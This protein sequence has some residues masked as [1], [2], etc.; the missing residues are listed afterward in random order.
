MEYKI[1]IEL[2]MYEFPWK[3]LESWEKFRTLP[4]TI[5]NEI[6]DGLSPLKSSGEVEKHYKTF[7]LFFLQLSLLLQLRPT[8]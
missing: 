6:T 4:L 3:I 7:F 2:P 8:R 5:T 1:P